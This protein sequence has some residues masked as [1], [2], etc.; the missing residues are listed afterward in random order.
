VLGASANLFAHETDFAVLTEDYLYWVRL[1]HSG[2][3]ILATSES[4]RDEKFTSV[5][6]L[7][8][9]QAYSTLLL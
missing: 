3:S 7:K 8:V 5:A 2:F 9:G 1:N 4:L 6:L